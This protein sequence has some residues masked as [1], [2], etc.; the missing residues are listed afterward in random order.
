MTGT[1]AGLHA[2]LP[3]R[4]E[5]EIIAA[6]R[7]R[8]VR[9]MGL[10]P[11]WHGSPRARGLIVGYSRP[12]SHSVYGA[13]DQLVTLVGAH[14]VGGD[15]GSGGLP[16]RWGVRPGGRGTAHAGGRS[17]RPAQNLAVVAAGQR[18]VHVPS[19]S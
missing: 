11:F 13:L 10:A 14:G 5:E 6:A 19:A 2:L 7:E 12:P 8:S 9:V 17:V 15:D 4:D 1:A 18:A 16:S 3:V